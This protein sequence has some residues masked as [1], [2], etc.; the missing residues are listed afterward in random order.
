MAR[1]F[2]KGAISF[3]MVAI[4]VK[5]Y[6]A[7]TI[8]TPAFHLLHKKCL[9][10]P[11]QVLHCSTDEVYFTSKD[12]VR[13]YE[14]AKGQFV[15]LD[16]SDF[17]RVRLKTLRAIQIQGFVNIDEID[18]IYYSGSHYLEPEELG[19]KPFVLLRDAL[20]KTNRAGIAK[21][22]FQRREHLCALRPLEDVLAL[23]TLH[24]SDEILPRDEIA[25]AKQ[26]ITPAEMDMAVSLINAMAA[27]FDP[28]A[29]KDEYRGALQKMIKAKT[30]G[31]EIKLLKEPEVLM[32]DLM[33][34]LRASIEAAGK[35][36]VT[37]GR[38]A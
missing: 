32:P 26:N 25:P 16:E 4:P 18:R 12:T 14:Y 1:A 23:H 24:F 13:G 2:W 8:K 21:V 5:M 27:S 17:D 28:E 37:A 34:A 15:V 9:T 6:T 29:Y 20:R 31:K 3:G 19:V 36:K 35:K 30:E 10:R 11:E 7:T 33:S 38:T 22:A